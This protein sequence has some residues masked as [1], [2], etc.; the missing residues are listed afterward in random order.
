MRLLP[1][2]PSIQRK[3]LD[4][5]VAINTIKID[6]LR[7]VSRRLRRGPYFH[8]VL[9][10]GTDSPQRAYGDSMAEAEEDST[11]HTHGTA[12]EDAVSPETADGANP[13]SQADDAQALVDAAMAP[14]SPQRTGPG[15]VVR[16]IRWLLRW[17]PV[18]FLGCALCLALYAWMVYPEPEAR[19]IPPAEVFYYDGLDRLYR[20]INPDLPLIAATPA[21]EALAARNAMLNL[22]VFYRD[23]LRDYPEFI[24][25]HLLLAETNRMLTEFN[26]AMAQK[27]WRDAQTAY[28]DASLWETR[29]DD[30]E[31]MAFYIDNNFLDGRG[32]TASEAGIP[33]LEDDEIALR[34]QRRKTYID[35]R[36]AEA[37]VNL[38]RP[39]LARPVL[40]DIRRGEDGRR[41]EELRLSAQEDAM[42]GDVPRRAFEL[43]PDEY[44][45]LDLLLAKAYDGLGQLDRARGW[46]LRYLA[47]VP[48]GRNH[49]FVLERLAA[50]SMGDGEV[51]RRVNSEAA[52]RHYQAAADYYRELAVSP[53]VTKEQH[54]RALEGLARANSRLAELVPAATVAG[55]DELAAAGRT[56][57]RWLEEFS[58]QPLPRRTLDLPRAVGE[59]LAKPELILPGSAALPSVV[60]GNLSAMAGG[61]LVT[62]HER[63]RLYLTEALENYDRLAD[64]LR[65]TGEGERAA[66]QAAWESW[67][68]GLKRE[69]EARFERMLDPLSSPELILAAR[70]GLAM[71]ALDNGELQRA[72]MLILGGY[73]HPMPLWFT[74]TDAD[75]RKIAVLLGTAANRAEPG[76]WRR[77]WE[78][79][80]TEGR[81]IASYAASGRRL[82]DEYVN[83]F[84]RALNSMLRREDFYLPEDFV[85][86]D[87]NFYLS[88][89]LDRDPELLTAE[90]VVWRNR[91]LLEEAWPYDLAQRAAKD[92]IGFEPF[93]SARE[94]PPSGLMEAERVRRLLLD[95][96]AAW[97]AQ[98]RAAAS[99][100]ETLRMILESNQ[101]YRAAMNDYGGEPGEILYEL[102]H[103]YETLAEI[104]ELQGN[105]LEA[106]SLTAEA[107][108]SY[109]DVSMKARGSPREMESLLSAGDAFFR[110]GLLGRTV[111]SQKRFLERFGYSSVP[112]SEGALAVVRAEN[113]L[114]RAYW[115]LKDSENALESFRR[116]IPRRVP[117][118]YKS[119]YYIGRVLMEEGLARNMSELLGS[120]GDPLPLF[121]RNGD[122][123]LDTA[124]HAFNFLRQ[125]PGINP[126]ARAWRW[127]TFDL[128][129][130]YYVF[131]ERARNQWN[132][133]REAA[134]ATEGEEAAAV[135][136]WLPLYDQARIVLTEALERYPLR[137]NGGFG[138]SVRVEPEDY[139]DV[140]ASRFDTEYMLGNTLLV[141]AEAREDDALSSMARAHL[142]NMRDRNRYAAALFDENL[143]RFQLNSAVIREEVEG[144][145]W[146]RN[147][148]LPRTRLGDDEGPTHSPQLMLQTLR[149]SMLLLGKEFFRAGEKARER[150][151]L[152]SAGGNVPQT[153]DDTAAGY[154]QNSYRVWQDIYDRFGLPYGSEAI[155]NMGDCL[156]RMG[157]PEDAANHYRMARNMSDLVPA[158]LRSDG[159]LDIGPAFWGAIAEQRLRDMQ[160]GYTVP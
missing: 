8:T 41:R 35:Y 32:G 122:P 110:A 52:A 75:W 51:F 112:G 19:T 158:D 134:I 60:A 57:R 114:G 74:P 62:P 30:A 20:V 68:L 119:M 53:S 84:L 135:R 116:N 26:P 118:R 9:T 39:E 86:R 1:V 123:I 130:L 78:T 44:R 67:N 129:K 140:M 89:I 10:G 99:R 137:R 155:V 71:V 87:R 12:D 139:A 156:N 69:T 80:P 13:E 149:N 150:Q 106:L 28:S 65:G 90:M 100:S 17:H 46:Y 2:L 105:H 34:R 143:D 18:L 159:V 121:D 4:Y 145:N 79:I 49:S 42:G 38:N 96:A 91:L 85:P 58:G 138:L 103:N 124:L 97:A 59:T 72:H 31:K 160:G 81:E 117:D 36:L 120:P 107:A 153:S 22:F 45:S 128:A 29:S 63:R 154:Y 142:E 7:P 56:L 125:S 3:T 108:R 131:A 76:V 16:S 55:V 92:N 14:E 54:D 144:G 136:P 104:R 61:G 5:H 101:A 70:L 141:L 132:A 50:I 147:T 11:S 24:N 115:F 6:Y 47:S 48:G 111:E 109:L 33:D 21:D 148:P 83:R 40:E 151:L 73:A 98:G 43:G 152:A 127:A 27:Y 113:L 93:P 15:K 157:Y 37:D 126:S 25:P 102:A 94:I 88:Y 82:D 146:D 64:I 95:L 77:I 133:E 23:T 66:I